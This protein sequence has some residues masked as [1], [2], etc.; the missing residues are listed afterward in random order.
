MWEWSHVMPWLRDDWARLSRISCRGAYNNVLLQ[1]SLYCMHKSILRCSPC[2]YVVYWLAF[3]WSL[4]EFLILQWHVGDCTWCYC[5]WNGHDYI[6]TA[7]SLESWNTCLVFRGGDD[8]RT[9]WVRICVL[10][11]YV[12]DSKDVE[13]DFSFFVF[14]LLSLTWKSVSQV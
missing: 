5:D 7:S 2:T 14:S 12:R 11:C 1:M 6:R 8:T 9:Q 4:M 10:C 3:L 13:S